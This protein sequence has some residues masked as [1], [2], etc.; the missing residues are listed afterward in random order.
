MTRSL[1]RPAVMLIALSTA[2]LL[3]PA[4]CRNSEKGPYAGKRDTLATTTT[5]AGQQPWGAGE[6]PQDARREY[7]QIEVLERELGRHL[8]FAEPAVTK[9]EIMTVT[10]PVRVLGDTGEYSRIQYQFMFFDE[11]GVPLRVQN[12]WKYQLLDARRQ[13]FLRGVSSDTAATWRLRVQLNR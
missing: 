12:D 3:G 1:T 9:G 6:Q 13:E 2:A 4:A 11:A 5:P 8:T 7:P 10:V